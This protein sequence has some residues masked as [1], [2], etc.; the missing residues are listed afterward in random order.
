METNVGASAHFAKYRHPLYLTLGL[1][2]WNTKTKNQHI[3][4]LGTE[5]YVQVQSTGLKIAQTQQKLD[6][7][8]AEL[9]HACI[10][11]FSQSQSK[12][13]NAVANSN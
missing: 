11:N 3:H 6:L 4:L 5:K 12:F 2:F 10:K 7:A 8:Q 13:K 1:V 9:G